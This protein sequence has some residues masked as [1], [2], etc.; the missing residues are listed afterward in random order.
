VLREATA[1]IVPA[2]IRNRRKA[3][4]RLDVRGQMG[5]VLC[6]LADEWLV[7]SAIQQHGLL[8]HAQL[9]RLGLERT[10][11][12]ERREVAL[13]LWSVL[14]LEWWARQF[15]TAQRGDPATAAPELLPIVHVPPRSKLSLS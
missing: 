13:R 11:V 1:G 7:D 5:E 10:Q 9:K 15:L 4:Q 12:R 3:M 6:E 8:T 14:S 2:R